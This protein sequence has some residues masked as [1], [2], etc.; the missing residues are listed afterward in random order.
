MSDSSGGNFSLVKKINTL[1]PECEVEIRPVSSDV[2]GFK[3][4]SSGAL[5]ENS[6]TDE[7]AS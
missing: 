3:S 2:E 5:S 1:F 7:F 6:I 4:S